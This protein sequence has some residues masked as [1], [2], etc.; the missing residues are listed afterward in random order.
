MLHEYKEALGL[1]DRALR[2]GAHKKEC[3]EYRAEVKS[4]DHFAN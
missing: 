4:I 3:E 2:H 1:I